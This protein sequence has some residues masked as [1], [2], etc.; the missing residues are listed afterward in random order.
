MSVGVMIAREK[1][2]GERL[3]WSRVRR[4]RRGW[5]KVIPVSENIGP[6]LSGID[7][8]ITYPLE[9]KKM[10]GEHCKT[11][12]GTK[13]LRETESLDVEKTLV[14]GSCCDNQHQQKI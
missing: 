3:A 7:I 9:E 5:R 14:K 6:V 13:Y 2:E 4:E 1:T 10:K 11:H 12:F 8:L